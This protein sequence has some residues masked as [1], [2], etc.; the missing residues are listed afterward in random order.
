MRNAFDGL[1]TASSQ[2][3]ANN[4]L[5]NLLSALTSELALVMGNQATANGLL[6]TIAN[7]AITPSET[8]WTDDS[9]A[10]YVRLDS[11]NTVSWTT[12]AGAASAPPG[13]GARPASSVN[14]TVDGSRYRAIAAVAGAYAVGDYL[15]HV[16]TADPTTGAVIASFW[17]NVSSNTRLAAAPA[18]A[19]ITPLAPLPDGAATAA[20][21]NTIIAALAKLA[22]PFGAAASAPADG[23]ATGVPAAMPS[24]APDPG[25]PVHLR[26]S[27]VWTGTVKVLSSR[28]GGAS[29]MPLTLAG[30]AWGVFTGNCNEDVE[31]PW[32]TG[33]TYYLD[34]SV[35]SGTLYYHLG[36]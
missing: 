30:D 1:A 15:N 24:F 16:V 17:V 11:G 21:Q 14:I 3:A 27:G 18:A 22:A 19:N 23:T 6:T 26:L 25:R 8:L 9:S 32:E 2:D 28:D 34:I 12:P 33:V 29:K 31:T 13:V 35:T 10:Y 7:A 4:I 5:A 20:L 36:Q